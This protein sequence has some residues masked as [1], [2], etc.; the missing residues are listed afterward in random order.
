VVSGGNANALI[1][2]KPMAKVIGYIEAS[3]IIAG[4]FAGSLDKSGAITVEIQA[5]TGATNE[6]GFNRMGAIGF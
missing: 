2:L 5:I 6:L 4:G 3:E 1:E